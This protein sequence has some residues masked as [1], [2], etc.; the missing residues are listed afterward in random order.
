MKLTTFLLLFAVIQTL[1][2]ESFSQGTKLSLNFKSTS[3]KEVLNSIENKTEYYFLYSSKVIDVERKIDVNINGKS[4]SEALEQILKD[5]DI[6]YV[7]KD[8]QILLSSISNQDKLFE[9]TQQQKSV[10]GK[11]T[12][13]S[14]TPLPGVSVV[15]KGTTTGV[16][17]DMD[18]KYTLAKVPENAML[19]FSFVGMKTQE[20][21]AEGNAMINVK[22]AEETVGL[23]EVVA[24]GY[25]TQKKVNLTGAVS[26]VKMDEISVNRPVS[27]VTNAMMGNIPGLVLTGNSGEPGSG[28]NIKIRG[29]SSINGGDPLILVDNIPMDID[30]INPMDI[31][32]ISVL[33]DASSAAVYGARAAF[34]VILVTTKK[35]SRDKPNKFN[36]SS[37]LSFSQ[38]QELAS[39]ATPLQTVTGMKDAG[40]ITMWTGQDITTWLNLLNEYNSDPTLYPDGY[41]LSGGTRY[42]LKET[43]VT[44]DLIDKFGVK[45]MH[46]FS[47]SGG[48]S[49]S[50]YRVSLGMLDENGVVVT[51]KDS[52]RRF[53][54]ASFL[55]T[56]VAS[57]MTTELSLLYS[58][59]KKKDPF[60][61]TFT[62]DV[63]S[64]T[65]YAPS[66]YPTDGM[67]INGVYMPFATPNH[68]MEVI[69][70]NL[71]R[72]NKWNLTGRLILKPIK[73]LNITGEYSF[74]QEYES[75]TEYKRP[76][77]NFADGMAFN[78]V[79][80]N[81]TQSTYK[82]TKN[83]N[84]Y[85]ALNLF[86][87]YNKR[88]AGHEVTLTAGINSEHSNFEG[89]W[90]NRLQMI[91]D[92]LPSI[93]QGIGLITAG[94][95]FSEYTIF[96]AFYRMNYS[97]KDKYLF[98]ASG[99]YDGSSKFPENNRFGFFPSFS[100]GWRISEENF[101][102]SLKSVISN[103][104]LRAS[105]GSIGNQN[106]DPY[107]YTPGMESF[108][109]N[110][111]RSGQKATSLK[112]PALVRSN[113]TWEEVRTANGGID[114]GAINNKVTASFDIFRRTTL[115]MLGPGA[116]Y[117]SVI[118][119]SAPLQNAADMRT[120]G[121]E[122]Q[123]G[124][125][126]KLGEV[127]YSLG[128]NL[129]DNKSK[130][131]RFNNDTKILS[132][133]YE[134]ENIGE[135]W[136]YTFDRFYT[137]D[138]FVEGSLKTTAAGELTGGTL[139][140][141]IAKV[142]GYNPNPGDVLFSYPDANGD[143]WSSK[144]TLDDPGS[145][146]VIGNSSYRYI[147]GF[148]ADVAW[149]GFSLHVLLQGVG[150][151]DV[152]LK[153]ETIIPYTSNYYIGLYDYQ[154]NYWTP[155]RT[156]AFYPRI[157][158]SAGYNT[159]ANTQVSTKYLLNA[160]YLDVKSVVLSYELAKSFV[161]KLHLDKVTFFVNG[162]NLWSFNHF[163]KGM[164]PDNKVRT[165]GATYPVM[166]MFTGGLNVAF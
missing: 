48:S 54:V 106:I 116:D 51:N 153:N 111:I 144:N 143:I 26:S 110:W 108:L 152:W 161:S 44:R 156:D 70:P 158:Q 121:W 148:N 95:D 60:I 113:F 55:S 11:V 127:A 157:Y 128:F 41:A 126:D 57:W 142:K 53:N 123:V 64:Q 141:G 2:F 14:G 84:S 150:K 86:A 163:P 135:I 115:N 102:T 47:V 17:T 88:I 119:A 5:T 136:G 160:A 154:L 59:G 147:F 58:N 56:D 22:L 66:F 117:P 75:L 19:Q 28:Y 101:M 83:Q 112:P 65:V 89:L 132:T 91:N 21:K 78:T 103:M 42:S 162:E 100:A 99:R 120:T 146:R 164:H 15:V 151:R 24:V 62:R 129:S 133:H 43:D 104:K 16:I 23:D 25:G 12:D 10:S 73:G 107:Q 4:I 105:W 93:G 80:S 29:T 52:Y 138:D 18:G 1:G 50:T 40:Y 69:I 124:W 118:G 36:Y 92:D 30:D 74:N 134:G 68:I 109:S 140:T 20:I 82:E 131:T 87:T 39:R 32:S 145:K 61:S 98:E 85:N 97:Y 90:A 3:L 27:S 137:A 63:W 77:S 71:S 9:N 35:S 67:D 72:T 94:D 165:D 130:I 8:R 114:F 166:R 45:Q 149:K 46:D 13:S 122:F 34:G 96:G 7:F 125:H 159:T 31:E 33:K 37:K 81:V 79:A 49:K 38:P 6:E 76:I 155:E 139:K